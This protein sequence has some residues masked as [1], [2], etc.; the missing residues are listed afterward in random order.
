MTWKSIWAQISAKRA[1]RE[2]TTK[3]KMWTCR[4]TDIRSRFIWSSLGRT[5]SDDL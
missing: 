4:R 3:H 2:P 5:L 1:V